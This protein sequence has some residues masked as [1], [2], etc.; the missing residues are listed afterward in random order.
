MGIDLSSGIMR[1]RSWR[2]F[3]VRVSGL[4]NKPP[5]LIVTPDGK[6]HSIPSTR[7]GAALYPPEIT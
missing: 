5:S 4:L 7:L 6:V 2:W 3:S 1:E